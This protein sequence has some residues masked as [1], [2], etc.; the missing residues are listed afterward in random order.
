MAVVAAV[1]VIVFLLFW[2]IYGGYLVAHLV[3]L[4]AL[5][6]TQYDE[7]EWTRPIS[8]LIERAG[9]LPS[10][11]VESVGAIFA[12]LALSAMLHARQQ[13]RK[14]LL[15]IFSTALIVSVIFSAAT[16]LYVN[17]ISDLSIWGGKPVRSTVLSMNQTVLDIS[18][19]LLGS[20][21]G[22]KFLPDRGR[23]Q[24]KK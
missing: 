3:I 9:Q 2:S 7:T 21:L 12:G 16:I 11:I 22:L 18:L 5:N 19:V 23:G 1:I 10:N 24:S 6:N 8:F 13:T 14:W 20:L 17:E 4:A 15:F